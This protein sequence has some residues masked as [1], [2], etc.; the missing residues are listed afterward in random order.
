MLMRLK[1]SETAVYGCLIPLGVRAGGK[2]GG[3]LQPPSLDF[4]AKH[5]YDSGKS[6]WDKLFIECGLYN[7]TKW[8]ILKS[9]NASAGNLPI[10][11]IC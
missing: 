5:L 7:T 9:F 11:G 3:I 10:A 2:G 1:K 4:R 8:F 6:N